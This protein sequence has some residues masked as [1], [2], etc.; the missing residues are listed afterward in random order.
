MAW[1]SDSLTSW[2]DIHIW[3]YH[4]SEK[5]EL[6]SRVWIFADKAVR[7]CCRIVPVVGTKWPMGEQ[8]TPR[9]T[10]TVS[11]G[12][13]IFTKLVTTFYFDNI[14]V[15]GWIIYCERWIEALTLAIRYDVGIGTGTE[16]TGTLFSDRYTILILFCRNL[17]IN[18]IAQRLRYGNFGTFDFQ[19][20]LGYR[21]TP[22]VRHQF[23]R[24]Q[25]FSPYFGN[26]PQKWRHE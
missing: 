20:S 6:N 3:E 18:Y 14:L 11:R 21:Q 1:H 5:S 7:C 2:D 19:S 12:W 9:R 4:S 15:D 23:C 8:G 26:P 10:Q 25:C 22:I 13:N 17:L 24:K 16:S